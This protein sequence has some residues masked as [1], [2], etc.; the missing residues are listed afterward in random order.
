[1]KNIIFTYLL[2]L[3]FIS[4][5][6][7][8]TLPH[9]IDISGSPNGVIPL[10]NS[11]STVW[12]NNGFVKYTKLTAPNGKA[13]HFVAQNQLTD[14]QIVRSRNILQFFLTNFEGSE[15]GS[16]KS[17]VA[18]QMTENDAVLLLLNGADGQGNDPDLPGQYLFEDEIAVEGHPW[19]INNDFEHRDAAFEEI[20]HLMHDTG[21]GVDGP[22]TFPGALTAYQSEIRAAQLNANQNNFAIW[23]IGADG[24]IPDVQDW[25]N[26]LDD[27]NSL[28]QEYL[29]S[30][31]DSYYGLW[32][33]FTD[34]PGGMW[35]IYI[36]KT[37]ADIENLD[38]AGAALMTKYFSPNININVDIDPSFNGTFSMSFDAAQLY[39]HKSQY[40]QHCTLTGSNTSNLKG[41]DLYNRL[42]GN[43]SDNE[44]EGGKGDD[45]MDGKAGD[46]LAIF[47]GNCDEYTILNQNDVTLV[48]DNISDRDGTDT[49]SNI[50]TMRFA[51][52]EVGITLGFERISADL[53]FK[54]FPNP[55]DDFLT[56]EFNSSTPIKSGL[57]KL[58]D[59]LGRSVSEREFETVFEQLTLD[60][61]DLPPGN[62][63]IQIIG[64]QQQSG[65]NVL[66]K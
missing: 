5:S 4:L 48:I 34:E 31:V 37:R 64:N 62:Y 11:V 36:A 66:I 47:T 22:N 65:I 42:T 8:Q 51:D 14:A 1:M 39:T 54:V 46:D 27:E 38:P 63:A 13:I 16:D 6:C 57:I 23:P 3:S 26:E 2:F 61:K 45:R 10:P 55:A 49:L 59:A 35:G 12:H 41:N 33:P 19:Y 28:S 17:V 32:G 58:F 50:E 7:A 43:D 21:I 9:D 60:V 20:L 56:V 25:F 40:L 52:K 30:V 53:V 15:F 29:A 44:L 18:N 24:S